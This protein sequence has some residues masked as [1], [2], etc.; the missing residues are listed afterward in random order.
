M[1]KKN[2]SKSMSKGKSK[3]VCIVGQK[4]DSNQASS[5][6]VFQQRLEKRFSTQTKTSKKKNSLKLLAR[7]DLH[8]G[9]FS[10]QSFLSSEECNDI[11]RLTEQHGYVMTDQRETRYAAHRRNGRIQITSE[12]LA[13]QLWPRVMQLFS[14]IEVGNNNEE[15]LPVGLSSNFRFYKYGI[16]D[17]FGMH[18]DDSVPQEKGD[19]YY[20]LL[21][22]LNEG[23]TGSKSSNSNSSNFQDLLGGATNFYTGDSTKKAKLVL[24]VLPQQ[25]TALIHEHYPH[26]MLHE[27][28]AVTR[29]EKFLMRT[30]VVFSV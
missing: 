20:T 2:K 1:P 3:K 8:D 18:I 7:K 27:G 6:I 4:R 23:S 17:R 16:G 26:C 19:T 10:I 30:D 28:A 13:E 12:V 25:G 29:G 5:H 21:V 9:I 11:I 24:S 14:P 15:S 22:Y